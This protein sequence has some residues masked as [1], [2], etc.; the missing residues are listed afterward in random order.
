M[1]WSKIR[2]GLLAAGLVVF[3]ISCNSGGL[4]KPFSHDK[5]P[6]GKVHNVSV[7]NMPGGAIISFTAPKSKNLLYVK[8]DYTITNGK[9]EESKVSFYKNSLKVQGYADTLKHNVSLYAVNKSGATSDS[10]NVIIK[11][12][13]APIL[14]IFKSLKVRPAF[15]GINVSAENPEQSNIAILI[16]QKNDL[17][18]WKPSSNS[19]YTSLDSVNYTLRGLDTLKQKFGFTV[20]DQW[21]NYTDTL[22]TT[23]KPLF[24]TAIPKSGYTGIRLPGDAPSN[25]GT[26][27]NRMWDG[28]EINWPN[29]YQTKP[30]QGKPAVITFGIGEKAK[31]S[32]VVIWDYPE[33]YNGRTYYYAEA[34][35]KFQIWGTNH[36]DGSG[37]FKNWT[38]LG[39]YTEHKPSGLPYGQQSNKDYQKARAGFSWP[40]GI[41]KP[42]VKYLRIK[43]LSN[44]EGSYWTCISELQV[45]GNP[46][47]K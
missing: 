37:S 42:A 11:P 14:D 16:L 38:L 19:I 47:N 36:I 29:V 26:T 8:A 27:I 44:W 15:G 21:L 22:F 41:N 43:V 35:K 5:T 28:D 17:G 33:Y 46:V 4:H 34:L 1:K 20:R 31:I 6:P 39:T 24:E 13:P 10:V 23:L 45:Y 12:K 3:V 2:L 40:V 9:H 25:Y 30:G 18:Q 7:N 32:R